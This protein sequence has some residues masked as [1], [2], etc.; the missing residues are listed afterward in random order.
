MSF[1]KTI[2]EG[3][4]QDKKEIDLSHRKYDA[5]DEGAFK[6]LPKFRNNFFE[7]KSRD[8]KKLISS[9]FIISSNLF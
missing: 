5:I 7:S 6:N 4:F 1:E 3:Q 8:E 2:K 9:H